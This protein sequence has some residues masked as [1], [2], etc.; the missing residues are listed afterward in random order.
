M[1]TQTDRPLT[2]GSQNDGSKKQESIEQKR[3]S[4][5]EKASTGR[6]GGSKSGFADDPQ[7]GSNKDQNS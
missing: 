3:P 1:A 4:G 2:S 7:H 5:G 6:A